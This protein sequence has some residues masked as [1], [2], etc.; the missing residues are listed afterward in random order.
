MHDRSTADRHA[1][2]ANVA[3]AREAADR[4][5]AANQRVINGDAAPMLVLWSHGPEVT[6]MPTLGDLEVGWE[7]VRAEWERIAGLYA[8]GRM[9]VDPLLVR[10]GGDLAYSV[11]I[12]HVEAAVDG[13]PLSASVRAT[14]V[15]RRENGTWKVVHHHGDALP[16]VERRIER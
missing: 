12:E 13:R 10:V 2:G 4:C 3:E 6:A 11:D 14:N 16:A 1:G 15:F 7:R 5:Y 8:D 9:T